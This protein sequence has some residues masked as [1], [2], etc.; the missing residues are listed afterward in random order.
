MTDLLRSQVNEISLDEKSVNLQFDVDEK[1]GPKVRF[2]G[3]EKLRE[4]RCAL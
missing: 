4:F 3:F 2:G 1:T